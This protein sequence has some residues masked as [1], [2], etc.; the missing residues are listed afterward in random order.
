MRDNKNFPRFTHCQNQN[1]VFVAGVSSYRGL[2]NVI[3][4]VEF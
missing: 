1:K 4:D 3:G 2:M